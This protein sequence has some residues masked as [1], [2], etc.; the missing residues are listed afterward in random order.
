[1]RMQRLPALLFPLFVLG[2]V[3]VAIVPIPS[4]ALDVLLAA[5]LTAA[6]LILLTTV[7]TPRPLEFS[8]FPSLLLGTTLGRL[9]LNIASTRLIL[10]R[11]AT[12]G[13]AAAGG[14]IAAFG[15]FVAG[16]ELIVGL[17]VF[18]ILVVVQF[19]VITKGA[20]RISEV[21]ARF[22][23]DALPGRQAA[24][25]ADVR[26]G[27]IGQQQAAELRRALAEQADFYGAMDGASK[28]VRGDAIAG[29]VITGVNIVG[30]LALG[31][32]RHGMPLHEATATFTTLTI[33]DGLVSQIPALLISLAAAL[34]ATRSS[35]ETELP[36]QITRQLSQHAEVLFLAAAFLL[37][38][39]VTGLPVLPLS[40]IALA[41][42]LVGVS[43]H[44]RNDAAKR[45]DAAGENGPLR[46][47]EH[48]PQNTNESGSRNGTPS[49]QPG[50]S[51]PAAT[52]TRR[53]SDGLEKTLG[54]TPLEVRLGVNLLRL[55]DRKGG[56]LLH[57]VKTLRQSVAQE[58]G[59]VFP[60]VKIRD[61]IGL[62]MN[63]YELWIRGERVAT[64]ELRTD[65]WLAI[66]RN[67]ST[68]TVRG[69]AA[70]TPGLN[71]AIWIT[72][73]DREVA[74]E[75]G[76]RVVPPAT[77]LLTHL[78]AVVRR[79]A[80][81]LLTREHVHELLQMLRNRAP[82]LVEELL[83]VLLPA[84][85]HLV[86]SGLLRENV[87][88]RDLER[89]AETLV[90][91]RSQPS[92]PQRIEM[93]RCAL[94]RTICAR[95]TADGDVAVHPLGP[96]TEAALL[97]LFA[98]GTLDLQTSLTVSQREQLRQRLLKAINELD[99]APPRVLLCA[100]PLARAAAAHLLRDAR[101]AI[102]V[103]SRA[104]LIA[105]VPVRN[106]AAAVDVP[107]HD[108]LAS[109]PSRHSATPLASSPATASPAA[110][111][112]HAANDQTV[113]FPVRRARR[114]DHA[115]PLRSA[116]ASQAE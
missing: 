98:Y 30:G 17:V 3:V 64:G 14:V 82:R 70:G 42:V 56:D 40:G 26:A 74:E 48:A 84:E 91:A 106:E 81:E 10:T 55:V 80:A 92:V 9:V 79:H 5:Q 41:C 32:L 60:K 88:I 62:P 39:A 36:R 24:I 37:L 105:D 53:E 73:E 99:T 102:P 18:L 38:L 57:R 61:D 63:R 100:E 15:D 50:V 113:P 35:T 104:E 75:A 27:L 96:G 31:M 65:A 109:V 21:A 107:V 116:V 93:V 11:G 54:V 20:S 101:G 51:G 2:A 33:G 76:Y 72:P 58:L 1:M 6:V 114:D 34:I 103:I 13:T 49:L 46:F 45:D 86:L 95:L 69:Q 47:S 77:A 25:D 43:T 66:P 115:S 68:A 4:A 29:L 112:P 23:L 108:L 16:G 28:F 44:R 59:F 22:T 78:E 90:T 111:E 71:A 83:E 8:V 12:D 85:I 89:I 7:Y 67:G 52:E 97:E 87:P 94:R 110:S 19:V